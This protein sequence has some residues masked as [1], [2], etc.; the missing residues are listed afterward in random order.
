MRLDG[1]CISKV[2]SWTRREHETHP[3]VKTVT[4]ELA[5]TDDEI[6]QLKSSQELEIESLEALDIAARKAEAQAEIDTLVT[7]LASN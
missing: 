7:V 6:E 5:F 2:E 4:C 1:Q 3:I